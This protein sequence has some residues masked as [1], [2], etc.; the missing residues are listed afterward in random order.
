EMVLGVGMG[1][2]GPV[3]R[4]RGV[5]GSATVLPGW[6]GVRA[7]DELSRRGGL[8]V[9]MDNDANLG[10]LA[11]HTVG[12]GRDCSQLAYIKLSNRIGGARIRN[13]DPYRGAA[14]P[15]GEIGPMRVDDGVTFCYC[16]NRGCL[17]TL[18]SG[19]A[20]Q[21]MLERSQRRRLPLA[22]IVAQAG[23]GHPACGRAV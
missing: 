22:E 12:A 10:A 17:E 4:G 6:A 18:A 2:P 9:E 5:V 13:G 16:G 1:I 3:D 20:V 19:C 23:A 8:P 15:A 7:A 14:G 11:E 21:E